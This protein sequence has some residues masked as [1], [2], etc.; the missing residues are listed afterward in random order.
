MNRSM[1]MIGGA[2]IGAGLM[3]LLDPDR[4][5]RRRALVRDQAIR[6]ARKARQAAQGTARDARNRAQGM[7]AS[8]TARVSPETS[9]TDEILVERV[10]SKLGML[11]RHPRSIEVTARLGT[12][13]LSGPVLADEV[14]SLLALVS[15]I[16]GVTQVD[17]RLDIH[18]EAGDVPGLQGGPARRPR[19]DVFELMQSNWSPAARFLAGAA[20]GIAVIYGVR[21]RTAAGAGLAA[22]GIG[23]LARG[24]TN[25]EFADVLDFGEGFQRGDSE[26]MPAG[27]AR[28]RGRRPAP[29]RRV[30]DVMTPGVEVVRPDA[31]LDEAA[32]KMK[33]LDVGVIPVCDGERLAGMLTDR[34]IV[35]RAIA[36]DQDPKRT[37]VR[38]AMT[39]QVTYC[40][41]DDDV[42]EAAM[43]MVEK[44]IRRLVVLN[45]DKRLV[46]IVSLGDFAVHTEN[47]RLSGEVLEYVSEPAAP[48]R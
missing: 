3:Y 42:E 29:R 8:M 48:R 27:R 34:D 38:E 19:G 4:G 28:S 35:V 41:E 16:P 32:Q 18:E 44:Q 36:E 11:V 10:R 31:T 40:F 15:K 6:S 13:I 23:L 21:Q 37:T 14:D 26:V 20:G 9:L 33:T 22:L 7:V 2:G 5:K 30:K 46:G 47:T 43:L 24:L 17:N 25:R 1:S 39:P 45:R 12:V